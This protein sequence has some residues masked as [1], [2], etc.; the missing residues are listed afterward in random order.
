MCWYVCYCYSLPL[1]FSLTPPLS[2]GEESDAEV[3]HFCLCKPVSSWKNPN[4]H[5]LVLKQK[6]GIQL[7]SNG[8]RQYLSTSAATL[9]IH[10]FLFCCQFE[11]KVAITSLVFF[12]FLT[13]CQALAI[14]QLLRS[15]IKP[16]ASNEFNVERRFKIY[17]RTYK[18]LQKMGGTKRLPFQIS[19]PLI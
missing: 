5:T 4:G 15:N 7:Y 6:I 10:S 17:K 1:S 2:R 18:N 9:S 19:M 12:Y 3:L 16:L 13:G 11:G 14:S 8:P